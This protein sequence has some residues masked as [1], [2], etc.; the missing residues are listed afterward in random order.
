MVAQ[1]ATRERH[2]FL[3]GTLSRKKENELHIVEFQEDQHEFFGS[4]IYTM[5][6]EVWAL[7]SS[8][9]DPAIV[10][11]S[12]RTG[13][14]SSA[15]LGQME[16]S[17]DGFQNGVFRLPEES[18]AAD[19]A[20]AADESGYDGGAESRVESEAVEVSLFADS[21]R[22]QE[23][24]LFHPHDEAGGAPSNRVMFMDD[25][26]ARVFDFEGGSLTELASM[27]VSEGEEA[28][29]AG[30]NPHKREQIV[31]ASGSGVAQWDLR[32]KK[33]SALIPAAHEFGVTSLDFNP[34]RAS[35]LVTSGEDRLV[36]FWDMRMSE[37]PLMTLANHTHWVTQVKYNPFHDQLITTAG[38][39]HRVNLW[40]ITS[41]SS[42]PL[43]ELEGNEDGSDSA[44]VKVLTFPEPEDS[45]YSLAW[46]A[47]TAWVFAS[48]SFEGRIL[49]HHV[50]EAEKYKILL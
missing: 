5:P 35:V 50:P 6:G 44:D 33:G 27:A 1:Q 40:R 16:H 25:T 46:S 2:R 21:P 3:A 42:Q 18:G 13:A 48:L 41:I 43:V 4:A 37:K 24:I 38:S 29:C 11:A 28:L 9:L 47:Y 22:K 39:D 7:A 36:K 10:A 26:Y 30:W 12:V 32:A 49:L 14:L 20:A 8:P 15:S 31:V 19:A 45:V 34:N 17:G 23:E